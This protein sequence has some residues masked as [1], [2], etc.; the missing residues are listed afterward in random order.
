M[1]MVTSGAGRVDCSARGG[2]R[3]VEVSIAHEA[4]EDRI[5]AQ[6]VAVVTQAP[7]QT[8]REAAALIELTN[9]PQT[10]IAGERSGIDWTTRSRSARQSNGN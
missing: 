5:V 10:G 8:T 6:A 1:A 3:V 4:F 9:D 7:R 2:P